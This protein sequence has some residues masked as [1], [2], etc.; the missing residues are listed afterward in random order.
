MKASPDYLLTRAREEMD[1][2]MTD[3]KL[4]LAIQLI[5]L[6]RVKLST[7]GNPPE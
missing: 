4:K 7:P 3:E 2:P 5:N 1:G 6:A